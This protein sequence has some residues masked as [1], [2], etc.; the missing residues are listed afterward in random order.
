M[1]DYQ[2]VPFG[3]RHHGKI[4][5]AGAGGTLGRRLVPML[6]REG[7]DVAAMTRSADKADLLRSLG[8]E[9]VIVDGLD[10]PAVMAAV[11]DTE[12]E[13]I[14]HEM[15]SLAGMTSIRRFDRAF[16]QTNLLRTEGL[17]H[18]LEA[19]RAAGV[20]RFVAQ[21]FG[22]WNYERRG[23]AIKT[24]D[25]PLD[26]DPPAAMRETLSALR[27][28]ED[29]VLRED[30]IDGVVLRY[31]TLYGPG[32]LIGEGGAMLAQV[33]KRRIPIVG[34][35]GGVWSFVH[36][37]DAAEATVRALEPTAR[38]IYN[39]ADDEPARVA[40]WLPELARAIGA[41][42][43][44]HIPL[45]AGRIVAGEPGVSL[46]TRIHGASNAKARRELNWEPRYRTWRDGFRRGLGEHAPTTSPAGVP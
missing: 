43:P 21:S 12:P 35:G 15:T 7:Y 4:L 41:K 26:P 37:D 19:A 2:S 29:A 18:L 39:I 10:R 25:D 30:A 9:P 3:A 46:F 44:H 14:V 5:V 22:N 45:W 34:D 24:E 13:A 32:A 17:D 20:R 38:G 33:R 23:C 1:S 11:A 27:H 40:T 8:A 28:L 31:A 36:V 42:P 6:V 16:A